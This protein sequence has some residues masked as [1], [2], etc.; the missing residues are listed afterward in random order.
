MEI[1][2]T[3][4]GSRTIAIAEQKVT[5]RSLHG[6]KSESQHVFVEAGLLFTASVNA[7]RP[8]RILEMGFGT[9][10]TTLLTLQACSDHNIE[11]DYTSI[12]LYPI[13]AEMATALHFEDL[14]H[15]KDL[16]EAFLKLHAAPEKIKHQIT[17]NFSF[18]KHFQEISKLTE[19]IT[20]FDLI[21]F[22]AFAPSA[23][24]ELW[25]QEIFSLLGSRCRPQA[26]LCTYCSKSIVRKAMQQAGWLVKKIQG[27]RGKREMVRAHWMGI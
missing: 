3:K 15:Q 20:G 14:L 10:L 23:Q 13:P 8:L 16:T 27:P 19:D 11:V 1:I 24:P 6:A 26:I 25:T 9:G 21:Y 18:T 2:I 4:D 5:Y 12:E 7:N 17:P 22:D